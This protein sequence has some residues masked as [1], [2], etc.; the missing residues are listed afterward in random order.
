MKLNT[1]LTTALVLCI[2]TLSTAQSRLFFAIGGLTEI[3][4]PF[5]KVPKEDLQMTRYDPDTSANA[6]VLL[7]NGFLSLYYGEQGWKCYL[8]SFK[9]VKLLKKSSF[10]DYGKYSISLHN[11]EKLLGVKAQTVNPDSSITP[12]TT[13][14]DEKDII[15]TACFHSIQYH[16]CANRFNEARRH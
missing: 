5:G 8:T 2:Y 9:R 7:D 13:F 12:V 3:E 14:F 11:S 1:F 16:P 4:T 6:V 15:S 10:D